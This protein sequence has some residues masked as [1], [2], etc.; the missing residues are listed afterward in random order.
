[1]IAALSIVVLMFVACGQKTS[2]ETETPTAIQ[3]ASPDYLAA[4]RTARASLETGYNPKEVTN[5]RGC[6]QSTVGT[7]NAADGGVAPVERFEPETVVWICDFDVIFREP[8]SS[9]MNTS[10]T[11]WPK[12]GIRRVARVVLLP[13]G[14]TTTRFFEEEPAAISQS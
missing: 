13:D 6:V 7:Y 8:I 5:D 1:M 14:G 11:A 4:Q 3:T 2:S 12:D 10:P 9:G